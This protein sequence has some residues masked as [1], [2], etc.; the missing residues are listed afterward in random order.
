MFGLFEKKYKIRL[1]QN[2]RSAE[3]FHPTD[4]PDGF[5][6]GGLIYIDEW[7]IRGI[8]LEFPPIIGM[9]FHSTCDS[10]VSEIKHIKYHLDTKSSDCYVEEVVFEHD[11]LVGF[12]DEIHSCLKK[13]GWKL[14]NMGSG[15]LGYLD[16][17]GEA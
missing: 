16:Y 14:A 4:N 2:I 10:S 7:W 3:T 11:T 6:A 8:E 12:I 5:P 1:I 9:G 17:T 15:T 13:D